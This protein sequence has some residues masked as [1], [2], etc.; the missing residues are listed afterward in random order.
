VVF[1]DQAAED[2]LAALRL[3]YS[4]LRV[5]LVIVVDEQDRMVPPLV[6]ERLHALVAR[7]ELLRVPGAGR[8]PQFSAPD[9]LVQA[10][11]HAAELAAL[12]RM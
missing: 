1:V 2:D 6:S 4:S 12:S 8:L 10:V 11:D 7:S 9:V 5:P 3:R